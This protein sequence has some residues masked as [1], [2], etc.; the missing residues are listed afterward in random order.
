MKMTTCKKFLSLAIMATLLGAGSAVMAQTNPPTADQMIDTDTNRGTAGNPY[1]LLKVTD[2][3]PDSTVKIGNDMFLTGA[4]NSKDAHSFNFFGPSE[5]TSE[6]SF[7]VSTEGKNKTGDDKVAHAAGIYMKDSGVVNLLHMSGYN[8]MDITATGGTADSEHKANAEAYAVIFNGRAGTE[9]IGDGTTLLNFSTVNVTATG[10]QGGE[11]NAVAKGFAS[12]GQN[13]DIRIQDNNKFNISAKGGVALKDS[14][15][16]GTTNNSPFTADATAVGFDYNSNSFGALGFRG[17]KNDLTITAEG[18]K[19]TTRANAEAVG[20]RFISTSPLG[21]TL[22]FNSF[23]DIKA[24]AMGGEANGTNGVSSATA[25]AVDHTTVSNGRFGSILQSEGRYEAR[26][27]AG[28]AVLGKA[29][30]T[31]IAI[32]NG[33]GGSLT[34]HRKTDIIATAVANGNDEA[35]LNAYALKADGS[36]PLKVLYGT[37]ITASAENHGNAYA[38]YADNRTEV[39][40]NPSA[41]E[42]FPTRITGAVVAKNGAMVDITLNNEHS[43]LKGAIL[44]E[45]GGIVDLEMKENS[46]WEW[47]DNG[48]DLQLGADN[49]IIVDGLHIGDRNTINLTAD[50]NKR[51]N[52]WRTLK[53]SSGDFNITGSGNVFVL[54]SDLANNQAD[55]LVVDSTTGDNKLKFSYDPYYDTD[56]NKATIAG[57]KA[58]VVE[59]GAAN[60]ANFTGAPTESGLVKYT[61]VLEKE[62][63]NIYLTGFNDGTPDKGPSGGTSTTAQQINY[64]T[65]VAYSLTR[66]MQSNME[67]RMGDLRYDK[68]HSGSWIH[69]THGQ[70]N[71]GESGNKQKYN[72]VQGG[73]DVLSPTRNA[74]VFRGI[75]FEYGKGDNTYTAGTGNTRERSV[76]FYQTS[77]SDTGRYYDAVVKASRTS[78][79]MKVQDLG[80]HIVTGDYDQIKYSASFEYGYRKTF[81]DGFYYQPESQLTVT[82]NEGYSYETNTHVKASEAS[83]IGAVG[84]LGITVG[85]KMADNTHLYATTSILHEFAGDSDITGKDVFDQEYKW[86]REHKNTWFQL[87]L[88]GNIK[89]G[90]DSNAYFNLEKTFGGD[91]ETRYQLNAGFRYSF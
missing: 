81:E 60:Q 30:A 19:A 76:G 57:K 8:N 87:I 61:P 85:K 84:R 47:A 24:Y 78:N 34:I 13:S 23:T 72:I 86:T 71:F 18:G 27:T 36:G 91:W 28:K 49:T 65:D 22:N 32:R 52:N 14:E 77:I 46:T 9:T 56:K 88:G 66:V 51:T 3:S 11:A 25:I 33:G 7:I 79:D 37:N 74:D 26:A 90:K 43:F 68:T 29:D 58:L 67:K 63:D 44:Q 70:N 31:A 16:A 50:N 40:I 48:K 89:T 2:A 39:T 12:F 73:Y 4:L 42:Y 17:M 6:T 83:S 62:G 75:F 53:S 15:S 69:M 45:T 59:G 1:Q 82:R 38:V 5:R 21:M 55:K 64:M 10:G 41:A 80:Y 35:E 20:V 54:N